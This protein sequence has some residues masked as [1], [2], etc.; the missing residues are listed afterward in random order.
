MNT[1]KPRGRPRNPE[2]RV[3]R[4]V[5]D[6][7]EVTGRRLAVNSSI[8]DFNNFAYRWINDTAVRLFAKTKQDD[9]DIVNNQG[10][11]VKEDSADLG[12]A[13]SY[14]TGVSADGSALRSYLCRKPK[15][16]YEED[17]KAAQA[18]LDEQ[19]AQLQR[20]NA[21]DG[22]NQS[23]YVPESGISIARAR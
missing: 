12:D 16:Y 5:R 14:V 17:K 1:S 10:G 15:A 8:L 20:G 11:A 22:A 21:A 23:D 18:A 7:E 19:L 2:N 4:R 13:V 9:W 6:V 3:R